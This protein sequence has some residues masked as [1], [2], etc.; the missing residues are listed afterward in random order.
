MKR[1][2]SDTVNPGLIPQPNGN[3]TAATEIPAD[4]AQTPTSA[5]FHVA[6][7]GVGVRANWNRSEG[8]DPYRPRRAA[9]F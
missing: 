1:P 8:H 6:H 4:G 2:L 5:D 3:V 7:S 9:V